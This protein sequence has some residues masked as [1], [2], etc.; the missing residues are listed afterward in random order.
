[1]NRHLERAVRPASALLLLTATALGCSSSGGNGAPAGGTQVV[2][3][4]LIIDTDMALDDWMAILYLLRRTDIAIRAITV[5]GTGEATCDLV[6]GNPR[7]AVNALGLLELAGRDDLDIPVACGDPRPMRGA[8][9]F[10]AAWRADA[11]GLYGLSLPASKRT[12]TATSAADVLASLLRSAEPRSV[13]VLTLGP[14]TNLGTVLA[15]EPALA[16]R[17]DT[18]HIMGGA[19]HVPGNLAPGG[20][21]DNAAAEYNFYADPTAAAVVLSAD[22]HVELTALDATNHVPVD[23][24]LLAQVR[25]RA[26]NPVAKFIADVLQANIDFVNSGQFFFWDPLAAGEV[27]DPS[28]CRFERDPLVVDAAEGA[29]SGQTRIDPRGR[30]VDVCVA[31]AGARFR[32]SFLATV[33]AGAPTP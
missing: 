25:A 33:G 21:K 1:M 28:L 22:L 26:T 11:D 20:V 27:A 32:A 5:A 31:A 2:R 30:P 6:A 3:R 7:G 17:I 8:H 16:G 10:P 13:D 15:R 9:A 14:E 24:D 23:A 19:V 4:P 29:T 12:P 18:V